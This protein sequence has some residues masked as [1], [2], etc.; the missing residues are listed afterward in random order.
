MKPDS[1][2]D[3]EE[4]VLRVLV[5]I[6]SHLDEA[7]SL[8]ELARVAS[9]SPY[10]FH[11]IFRGMVGESVQAHVR[12]LRLERAA[13][14]LK[15]GD[16]AVTR[17]A[18]DAGYEAHEAF[19]RA[20]RAMFDDSPSHFREAHRLIPTRQ[21]PSGVHYEP[22]GGPASFEPITGGD[23][24]MDARVVQI[25]PMRV[26][27]VRHV[28]PYDQVG[29]AWQKLMA[30]AGPNGLF[31]PSTVMCGLVH[32]DPE[33]TPPDRIRYD[34]CITVGPDFEP[35]GDVGVQIIADGDYAVTTH[36]GPY[37]QLGDTYARLCGQWLP[38]VGRELR[39][40]PG[41]EVYHNSPMDTAPADLITDIHMPL[42]P[43]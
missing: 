4:R 36:H 21:V 14:R 20:F 10:H 23:Q 3:Y 12:R 16:D 30:F 27:F 8:D 42:E 13:H 29:A 17:I 31:G 24:P 34:A 37:D 9:F 26:A 25:E 43:R 2:Q 5:H 19:T 15:F 33:I 38:S 32:D 7:L 39:S 40:A 22:D 6:Q 1:R 28:G 18:F 11:R 41:F 35:T